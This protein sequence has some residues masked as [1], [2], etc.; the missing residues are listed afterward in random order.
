M[1]VAT[2]KTETVRR[3]LKTAPPDGFIVL[4]QL[5]FDEMLERRDGATKVLMERGVGG[6]NADAKMAVQ[7]A[8]KWSN[9]FS[10]PRCIVEHNLTD[11]NGNPLDFTE[12]GI[13]QTFRMLDPKIG[14][15]IERLV[16][17][18]NQEEEEPEGFT[19]APYSSSPDGETQPNES[20]VGS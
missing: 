9:R 6:R 15:E 13:D 10:F 2:R 19:N 14:A 17:E 8:N 12:R 5:S 18:L 3:E 11:E 7:I 16:D 20:L 1:P 4:R